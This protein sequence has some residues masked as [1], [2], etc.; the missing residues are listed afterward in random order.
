MASAFSRQL[1]AGDHHTVIEL[2]ERGLSDFL[3][4]FEHDPQCLLAFDET[5]ARLFAPGKLLHQSAYHDDPAGAHAAVDSGSD[6]P[7]VV[8]PSGEASKTLSQV[9]RILSRAL[10]AGLPRSATFL[11][12][13]GGAVSD[14]VGFSASLYLRGVPVVFVPT[15]LLGMVDASIG[16]KTGINYDGF[17]NMVGTFYPAREV[18]IFVD[19]LETLDEREFRSGLAEVIKA[20]LLDDEAILLR[21][22]E[23]AGVVAASTA[24]SGASRGALA[25]LR[26]DSSAL[27]EMIDRAIAVKAN[28][29]ER[30]FRESGLRAHLNLGHTFAHALEASVGLGA[31][32][33]GDAV[34]WGICRALDL[35]RNMGLTDESYRR[36]VYALLDAYGFHTGHVDV[37]SEAVIA[38][39]KH[40]KKRVGTELR[41]VL[42][43]RL[44]DTTVTSID[45][46]EVRRVLV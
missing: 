33:H 9:Q 8:L 20:G 22:E 13:G 1:H 21:L 26:G 40:D 28:V 16:G 2:A 27:M 3:S 43:R 24:G 7:L 11:A 44:G 39:M 23:L 12:V 17:K 42:Q 32:T 31:W 5:T 19:A 38:A 30:D 4:A 25:R 41:F 10:D 29:V 37:S 18:R 6:P 36:R 34:A 14:V 15:T 46:A 45:E 35:G